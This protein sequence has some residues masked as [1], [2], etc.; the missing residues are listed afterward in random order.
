MLVRAYPTAAAGSTDMRRSRHQLRQEPLQS[1]PPLSSFSFQDIL[2]E[3]D[4]EIQPSIDAIPEIFGRSKLSLADE[5]SSHLPPQGELPFSTSASPNEVLEAIPNARL[6]PV[7]EGRPGNA[8]R[9]SLALVGTRAAAQSKSGA[10]AATSTASV[11][12]TVGSAS[13]EADSEAETKASLLPYVL[14]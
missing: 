13:Q 5:Y 2:K 10:V 11:E 1:L 6:E 4:P 14:S 8:R 7:E 9:Q 12:H 3:I